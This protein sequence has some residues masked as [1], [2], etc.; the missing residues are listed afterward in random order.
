MSQKPL[1]GL[2]IYL[3][4]LA[5]NGP[6]GTETAAMSPGDTGSGCQGMDEEL[7]RA[8]CGAELREQLGVGSDSTCLCTREATM[9]PLP[10]AYQSVAKLW[11]CRVTLDIRSGQLLWAQQSIRWSPVLGGPFK[12]N[13]SGS[14]Q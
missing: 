2:R 3:G 5:E 13:H 14:Y 8:R 7:G 12:G 4:R 9:Q 6:Q 11:S 10:G 1:K